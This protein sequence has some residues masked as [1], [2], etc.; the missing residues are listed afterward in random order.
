MQAQ[1]R[2]DANMSEKEDYRRMTQYMTQYIHRK[3]SKQ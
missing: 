2:V 3:K 1:V